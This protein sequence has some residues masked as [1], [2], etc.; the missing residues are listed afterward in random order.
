MVQ[1]ACRAFDGA[2]RTAQ[3]FGNLAYA[4]ASQIPCLDGRIPSSILLGQRLIEALYPLFDITLIPRCE[5][6]RHPGPQVMIAYR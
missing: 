6:K 4:T 5:L 3:H 2:R 1:L